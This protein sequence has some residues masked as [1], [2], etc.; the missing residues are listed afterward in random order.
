MIETY[1]HSAYMACANKLVCLEIAMVKKD[2]MGAS[3]SKLSPSQP[4]A[5]KQQ[6]SVTFQ[7][8]GFHQLQ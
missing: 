7:Q 2:G 6:S 4:V 3:S 1:D 8:L 5:S